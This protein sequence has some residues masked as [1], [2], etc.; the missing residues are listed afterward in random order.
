MLH[1]FRNVG[2]KAAATASRNADTPTHTGIVVAVE[3]GGEVVDGVTEA[4]LI[5]KASVARQ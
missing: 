3:E 2:V 4:V 1:N 5:I